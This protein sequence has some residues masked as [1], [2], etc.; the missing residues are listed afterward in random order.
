MLRRERQAPSMRLA[1]D[2]LSALS[3]LLASE[4]NNHDV[5][6]QHV[7]ST[8]KYWTVE[9]CSIIII[10]I[11]IMVSRNC[12][13]TPLFGLYTWRLYAYQMH[14]RR[15]S[16][17]ARS[18]AILPARL[19]TRFGVSTRTIATHCSQCFFFRSTAISVVPVTMI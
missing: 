13:K 10:I 14:T 16:V 15:S 11:I 3:A 5:P 17:M 8:I 2:P 9:S 1:G 18:S 4:V 19:P 6:S 12:W 7:T